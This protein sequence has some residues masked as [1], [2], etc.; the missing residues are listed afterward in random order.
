[1]ELLRDRLRQG[2]WMFAG[3]A[4]CGCVAVAVV[5]PTRHMVTPPCP[6]RALTGWW[7]PFCGATRA[8]SRLLR[9]DLTSAFH[10]NAMFLLLLPLAAAFWFAWA[11]PARF[12]RLDPL[13][14]RATPIIGAAVALLVLFTVVRNTP[15]GDTWLRY[16]GA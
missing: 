14:A 15:L 8:A 9:G 13:R 12:T 3:A 11:F 6:M 10:Y 1:M 5:D 2:P 16:P 4:V 7:C